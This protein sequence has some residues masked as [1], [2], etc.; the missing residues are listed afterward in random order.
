MTPATSNTTIL[1]GLLTASLKEPGPELFKLVTWYTVPDLPPVANLPKPSAPGKAGNC[2]IDVVE[3]KTVKMNVADRT[4]SK[5][6]GIA[7]RWLMMVK[8]AQRNLQPVL[9]RNAFEN[10][11][12]QSK[13]YHA[14]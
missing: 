6:R 4:R 12:I 8:V 5:F 9:L 1:F 3:E 11:T 14:Y 10:K 2:A 7:V 13:K